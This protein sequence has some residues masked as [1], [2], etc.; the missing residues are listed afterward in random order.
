MGV[1]LFVFLFFYSKSV[2]DSFRTPAH[3][4]ESDV[5]RA[6]MDLDLHF[7]FHDRTVLLVCVP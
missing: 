6:D 1:F 7:P 4:N 5:E 2:E 3:K